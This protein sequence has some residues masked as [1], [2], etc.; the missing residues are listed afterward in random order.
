MRYNES[1]Y[2]MY[3]HAT[4]QAYLYAMLLQSD[5]DLISSLSL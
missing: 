5:F 4:K 3:H 1:M 2:E